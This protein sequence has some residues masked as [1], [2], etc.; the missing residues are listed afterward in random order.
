MDSQ[1]RTCAGSRAHAASPSGALLLLSGNKATELGLGQTD[2]WLCWPCYAAYYGIRTAPPTEAT[3][4]KPQLADEVSEWAME[5]SPHLA[6]PIVDSL[7]RT[8]DMDAD[9]KGAGGQKELV[10]A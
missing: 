7:L 4:R 10:S 1:S 3:N 9:Y 8:A 2:C 5:G 6:S